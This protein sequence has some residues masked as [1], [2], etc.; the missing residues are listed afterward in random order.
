MRTQIFV[1]YWED[2]GKSISRS[3]S[4]TVSSKKYWSRSPQ[5]D[6]KTGSTRLSTLQ[7]TRV[8]EDVHIRKRT[9]YEEWKNG[10]RWTIEGLEERPVL[11]LQWRRSFGRTRGLWPSPQRL[12]KCI[13]EDKG[14][15]SVPSMEGY[16]CTLHMIVIHRLFV[17]KP[18]LITLL[19]DTKGSPLRFERQVLIP[20]GTP[21]WR[22]PWTSLRLL[23]TSIYK[24]WVI[25]IGF[26]R[27][28][29]TKHRIKRTP[30]LL[31]RDRFLCHLY[32]SHS[33][34]SRCFG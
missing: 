14:D 25:R 34:Y 31:L 13:T 4:R 27:I 10:K 29:W 33:V 21:V 3:R 15:R 7:S 19:G 2:I 6:D 26:K 30:F 22:T 18:L 12:H 32:L 8:Q 11:K 20:N 23:L 1:N 28:R 5:N 9:L 24:G 16:K 17:N